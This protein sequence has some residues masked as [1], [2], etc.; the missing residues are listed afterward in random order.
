MRTPSAL[1][2][3]HPLLT[4]ALCALALGAPV[5]AAAGELAPVSEALESLAD[6]SRAADRANE[7]FLDAFNGGRDYSRYERDWHEHEW[8]LEQ[9][10]VR[11]LSRATGASESRIRHLRESG[12]GWGEIAHRYDV[13]PRILGYGSSPHDR[14]RDHWRG[15][16]PKYS[17][18]N[19]HDNGLHRGQR[20]H[21]KD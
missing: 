7:V 17:K 1:P 13:D 5:R 18:G 19:K 9:A 10:R 21:K 3:R 11:A 15:H 12:C 16:P 6:V 8:R 2:F 20:K 4:L 14:D